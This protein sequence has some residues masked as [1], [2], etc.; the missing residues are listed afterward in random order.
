MSQP[1]SE[2]HREMMSHMSS[3]P[4][5]STPEGLLASLSEATDELKKEAPQ[6]VKGAGRTPVIVYEA[7][8]DDGFEAYA[9]YGLYATREQA[10]AKIAEVSK[11]EK[12]EY[13][14]VTERKIEGAQA[15]PGATPTPQEP[16]T[17]AKGADDS[18]MGLRPYGWA[19]GWKMHDRCANCHG[20]FGPAAE[21]A[22][23]CRPCAQSMWG[24]DRLAAIPEPG[25]QPPAR[26]EAE[27]A[28]ARCEHM[29]IPGAC[30]HCAPVAPA[31]DAGGEG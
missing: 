31:Q 11:Q 27:D 21:N 8:Y 7:R 15:N 19:P 28:T 18:P 10:E 22:T 25:S 12:P 17:V 2:A 4:P 16:P 23:T 14:C 9:S 1:E 24:K 13:L 6:P 30:R 20:S 26:V 5:N 3:V 29:R